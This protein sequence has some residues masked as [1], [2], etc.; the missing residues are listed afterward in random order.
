MGMAD[1]ILKLVGDKSKFIEYKPDI[2]N[3]GF[4]EKAREI[5]K[6]ASQVDSRC[7][8]FGAETHKYKFNPVASMEKVIDFEKKY[9]I[10]LPE[11][12]VSFLTQVGNGGA[13][14]E[15]GL[16]SLEHIEQYESEYLLQDDSDEV[17]IDKNLTPE[18]W[19]QTVRKLNETDDDEA[20]ILLMRKIM[21]GAVVIGSQGCT[22]DNLLM[23]S[24]SQAGKI[25]YWDWNMIE[26]YPPIFSD[27]TF[28]EWYLE[29]FH[30]IIVDD[31]HKITSKIKGVNK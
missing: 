4:P 7:R 6:V 3:T 23:C 12:Y 2:I 17:F 30:K 8:I 26:D 21:K 10:K 27:K 19:S 18:K 31:T 25:V 22:F 15:Y 28:E 13:A 1:V 5:V 20:Y 29:Y 9:N 11:A 14:P 24:G 16:Y